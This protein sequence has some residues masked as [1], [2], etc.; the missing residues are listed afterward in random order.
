MRLFFSLLILTL[1]AM[2]AQQQLNISTIASIKDFGATG[3]GTTDDLPALNKAFAAV[4]GKGQR[5]LFPAGTYGVSGTVII[6]NKTQIYGVGRGDPG[7]VNTVIKALPAF[8]PGEAVVEMGPPPGPN[9]GIE[10]ENLTID[11]ASVAGTCL[12]NRY[13]QELSFG[14]NLLLINCGVRGLL[15]SHVGQN[16]GP[17]ENLEIDEGAGATVNTNTV[18]VQVSSAGAFRGIHGLTCNGGSH[19]ASRPAVAL[20]LDGTGVY[21]DIHVEHFGTAVTLG[22]AAN[23]ADGLIFA[24][25]SFGPDVATGLAITSAPGVNNQNLTLLGISCTGCTTLLS[26]AMTGTKISDTSLGWYLLG[27][28]GPNKAILSSNYGIAG[29]TTGPFRAP[30]VQLTALG[31]QPSCSSGTRGTFWFVKS[32]HGAPDHLQVCGKS[33]SDTYSWVTVF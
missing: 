26:D 13:A 18:C 9:F 3:N 7:G 11:G 33:A 5:L 2:P 16:S 6:P 8:L 20:A 31:S 24:D 22:N 21:Q 23:S 15:V 10:V 19:Y 27:N 1:V 28:G 29:Q 32:P 14:R 30:D 12:A 25:G 4:A 17:F